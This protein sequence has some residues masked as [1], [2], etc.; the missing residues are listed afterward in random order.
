[1]D[2]LEGRCDVLRRSTAA[3]EWG[4]RT[5]LVVGSVAT[6]PS[7]RRPHHLRDDVGGRCA[8]P[9][10]SL[11]SS[12]VPWNRRDGSVAAASQRLDVQNLIKYHPDD[13]LEAVTGADQD[14]SPWSLD[15]ALM[16]MDPFTWCGRWITTQPAVSLETEVKTVSSYS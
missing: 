14:R 3:F 15:P 6:N 8:V 2:G 5:V 7:Y 4:L 13:V 11:R 9:P 16:E 1:M 12:V 10:S